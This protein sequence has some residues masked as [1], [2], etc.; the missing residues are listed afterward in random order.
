MLQGIHLLAFKLISGVERMFLEQFNTSDNPN[1]TQHCY[2]KNKKMGGCLYFP[3]FCMLDRELPFSSYLHH[4]F[5]LISSSLF[6]SFLNNFFYV[7]LNDYSL[8]SSILL[9]L[10]LFSFRL[11][12][13]LRAILFSCFIHFCV[14]LSKPVF[15]FHVHGCHGYG[16]CKYC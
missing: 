3:L 12:S 4:C 5:H 9:I 1:K 16:C 15:C 7:F 6:N 13:V 14:S 8:P 10:S 2:K 11:T